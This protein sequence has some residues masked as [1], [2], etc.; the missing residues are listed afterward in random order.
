[1]CTIIVEAPIR[2]DKIAKGLMK[3]NSNDEAPV[4]TE[5]LT[6]T[7]YYIFCVDIRKYVSTVTSLLLMYTN[8]TLL[9]EF[10]DPPLKRQTCLLHV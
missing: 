7:G 4:S 8:R 6:Y 2:E 10:L 5:R 3:A 1:M 9:C